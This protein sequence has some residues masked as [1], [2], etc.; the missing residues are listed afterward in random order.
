MRLLIHASTAYPMLICSQS[1]R[2]LHLVSVTSRAHISQM[3]IPFSTLSG[4]ASRIREAS[5][6]HLV[7]FVRYM[8]KPWQNTTE[9]QA[10]LVKSRAS[11]NSAL[12]LTDQLCRLF[13]NAEW[14]L[15]TPTCRLSGWSNYVLTTSAD[16][17]QPMSTMGE[18]PQ[19]RV[20]LCKYNHGV[21]VT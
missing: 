17:E 21:I 13:I 5:L 15:Q 8:R 7:T 10:T 1:R 4:P 20:A 14:N 19:G 11:W 6:S 16:L 9:M 3:Y 2:A 18:R 12:E